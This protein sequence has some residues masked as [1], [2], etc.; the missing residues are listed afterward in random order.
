MSV[1]VTGVVVEAEIDRGELVVVVVEFSGWDWRLR[2]RLG[3]LIIVLTLTLRVITPGVT[4]SPLKENDE[5]GI[6]WRTH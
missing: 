4:S 1:F 3:R 2:G 5:Y 6:L